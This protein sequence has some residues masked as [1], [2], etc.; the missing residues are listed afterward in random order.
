ML[1]GR[2]NDAGDRLPAASLDVRS[3][4][5]ASRR[6]A[7]PREPC[8]NLGRTPLQNWN[9]LLFDGPRDV[10]R[11]LAALG[12]EGLRLQRLRLRPGRDASRQ[13]Q[14]EVLH[15]GLSRG[16]P[17]RPVPSR[18]RPVR[19]VRRPSLGVRRL[20]FGA[21]GRRQQQARQARHAQVRALAQGGARLL[22]R[23]NPEARRHLAHVLPEHHARVVSARARRSA[24]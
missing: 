22:P 23:R 6:A 13:L 15:R 10:A 2:G 21:D 8:L 18:A 16:L 1:N 14:L 7:L 11:D 9:G 19:D 20:V 4:R 24:R 5:R 17:R 3:Q 12:V